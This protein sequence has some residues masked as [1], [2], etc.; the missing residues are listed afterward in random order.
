MPNCSTHSSSSA[1]HL[2]LRVLIYGVLLATAQ[3]RPKDSDTGTVVVTLSAPFSSKSVVI[4][5]ESSVSDEGEIIPSGATYFSPTTTITLETTASAGTLT[6]AFNQSSTIS[7]S[8]P[9][10]SA[11]TTTPTTSSATPTPTSKSPC[12]GYLEFCERQYSNIT[13]VCA[14][15]SPFNI[16]GDP[17]SNQELNVTAQLNDGIRM[18]QGQVH[19]SDG[20]LHYCHTKCELI[21]A[22]P[23][24]DYLSNVTK[25]LKA[26]PNEVVTILMGNSDNQPPKSFQ[27][28]IQKAGL[29]QFAYTP[30]KIP[31]GLNDW[32]TLQSMIDSGKRAVIYLDYG[33]DQ[34]SVPY[35]L[36]QFSQ[37]WETPFSPTN[38]SFPC[39]VHRPPGLEDE[40]AANRMYMANHNLNVEVKVDKLDVLLPAIVELSWTNGADG[41]G[42][43]GEMQNTCLARWNRAPSFLLVDYYNKGDGSVFRVAADANRVAY[44][45][46]CCTSVSAGMKP[47]A[48]RGVMAGLSIFVVAVLSL[49]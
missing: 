17:F 43:L 29:E 20:T 28:Q 37:L 1:M 18:L 11:I 3:A 40:H 45:K 49:L 7:G 47:S 44:N 9:K 5:L 26:N 2:T 8:T 27:E 22:G 16:R 14:H 42:S 23:I 33:A 46:K 48:P 25:W 38:R 6:E 15:N 12:N 24:S 32:P 30:P 21:D 13:E 10:S 34:K 35:L 39:D 36:D 41:S 19:L 4:T 31:M